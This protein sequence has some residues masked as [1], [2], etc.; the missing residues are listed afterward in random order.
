[1]VFKCG[2][3]LNSLTLMAVLFFVDGYPARPPI[4]MML[5]GGKFVL[6]HPN[7]HPNGEFCHGCLDG[8]NYRPSFEVHRMLRL[9]WQCLHRPELRDAANKGAA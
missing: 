5:P 6:P 2:P 1:M 4:L 8:K 3:E 7:V 9:V